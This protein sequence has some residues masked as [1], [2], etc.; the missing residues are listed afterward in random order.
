M[1][2]DKVCEAADSAPQTRTD[3]SE[4]EE[5]TGTDLLSEGMALDG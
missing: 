5:E 1:D 4:P 2:L 3:S